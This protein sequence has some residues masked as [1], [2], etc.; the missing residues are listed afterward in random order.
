ME[1]PISTLLALPDCSARS[2]TQL[3]LQIVDVPWLSKGEIIDVINVSEDILV[4]SIQN[5]FALKAQT[6]QYFVS[7][8]QL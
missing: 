2:D 5:P 7:V 3:L 1:L 6:Q 4:L 8:N